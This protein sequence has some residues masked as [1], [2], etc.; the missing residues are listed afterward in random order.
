MPAA[1]AILPSSV[2]TTTTDG[3]ITTGATIPTQRNH[4]YLV[5]ARI[6]VTD[7]TTTAGYIRAACFENSAGT[8]SQVGSTTSVAT[9]EDIAAPMDVSFDTSGTEIRVRITGDPGRTLV[10]QIDLDVWQSAPAGS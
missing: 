5:E 6:I 10:W 4:S 1:N 3:T 7:G 8:L 2:R 9:Y